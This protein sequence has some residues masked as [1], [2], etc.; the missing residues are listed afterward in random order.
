MQLELNNFTLLFPDIFMAGISF[1]LLIFGLI[2]SKRTIDI[3]AF[4]SSLG[5]IPL[6][7]FIFGLKLKSAWP[8]MICDSKY[9]LVSKSILYFLSFIIFS[10]AL[11]NTTNE[12]SSGYEN[13]VIVMF[14]VLGSSCLISSCSFIP[15]YIAVEIQSIASYA[16]L[17]RGNKVNDID[18]RETAVKYV[19]NG[20]VSSCV[21]LFGI[22]LI[23]LF[24][25]T[26]VFSEIKGF[27]SHQNNGLP[28]G[29]ILGILFTFIGMS[30]K[31]SNFPIHT[32]V[33]NV[34]QSGSNFALMVISTI[35]KLSFGMFFIQFTN[36]Y[37]IGGGNSHDFNKILLCTLGVMSILIG[38]FGALRQSNLKR[39][40]GYASISHMGHV[41]IAS[42]LGSIS[43]ID[44]SIM[45]LITYIL[46]TIAIFSFLI[47]FGNSFKKISDLHELKVSNPL[48]ALLLCILI[49]SM[50]GIPPFAG[51][52]IKFNIIK[53]VVENGMISLALLMLIANVVS[54]YYYLRIIKSIYIDNDT[55]S[56][57]IKTSNHYTI[58]LFSILTLVNVFYIF[59]YKK[60]AI[61]MS[62]ISMLVVH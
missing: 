44:S 22:S 34:Y 24:S 48:S 46:M 55:S 54:C 28:S 45:Y 8:D 41:V 51:F 5:L 9:T 49:F 6:S 18:L 26:M 32:W 43:G 2:V 50:A 31:L 23:Y 13:S 56:E 58:G 29:F 39:M 59:F 37:I 52:F 21:M 57:R 30:F 53:S 16:I 25:G 11:S 4:F 7:I 3:V 60:I 14:L 1:A 47:S 27:I 33:P 61:L 35:P 62:S 40:L 20:A 12:K 42:S 36:L 38:S 17:C 10:V 19:I 15:M